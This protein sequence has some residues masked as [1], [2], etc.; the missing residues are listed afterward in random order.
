MT[1]AELRKQAEAMLGNQNFSIMRD[2]IADCEGGTYNRLFGFNKD[3]SPRYFTDMTKFPDSPA[4]YRRPDGS[5]GWSNDA[6]RYQININTY[7]RMAK[8]LGINDFSERSQDLIANALIL[9]NKKASNAVLNGDWN[10]AIGGLRGVWKSIPD[11]N[12][13]GGYRSEQF[14][15]D[16]LNRNLAKY[17]QPAY[18]LSIMPKRDGS[19][20]TQPSTAQSATGS[21]PDNYFSYYSPN[22]NL[23]F[24]DR[25]MNNIVNKTWSNTPAP[26]MY[27]GVT[28][29]DGNRTV[30]SGNID[31][32]A[33][34][35]NGNNILLSR[36]FNN[37]PNR[38]Y[39]M[40]YADNGIQ[41]TVTDANGTRIL[42]DSG[43]APVEY[44][45]PYYDATAKTAVSTAPTTPTT[46]ADGVQLY[47][48][49]QE[50]PL[51]PD[52]D[53]LQQPV[54][55]AT[56]SGNTPLALESSVAPT[57]ELETVSPTETMKAVKLANLDNLRVAAG[58]NPNDAVDNLLSNT[59]ISRRLIQSINT[60]SQM[61]T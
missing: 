49:P 7:K 55:G 2:I 3:G 61:V 14:V 37:D 6:G 13:K 52:V 36:L 34:D 1:D 22:G 47:A 40:V 19:N 44:P 42:D 56:L 11:P 50:Q 9:E 59:D 60:K 57:T 26:G 17:K 48:V 29:Q 35:A 54:V 31:P 51:A 43:L 45:Q 5:I 30:F 24:F 53:M 39:G 46:T 4:Q 21:Y 16:S 58:V 28:D 38:S 20:S 27:R 8:R 18:E 32:R 12:R 10:N 33:V 15:Q 41:P 25:A 23:S